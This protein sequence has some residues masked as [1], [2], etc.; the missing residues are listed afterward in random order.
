MYVAEDFNLTEAVDVDLTK[1]ITDTVKST[2]SDEEKADL[3]YKHIQELGN[4][5]KKTTLTEA[6]K[7]AED[8]ED[9]EEET[10][11]VTDKDPVED[12][13]LADMKG[14]VA[15]ALNGLLPEDA[16]DAEL[17]DTKHDMIDAVMAYFDDAD[18]IEYIKSLVYPE[19]A[20]D[21]DE[22]LVD[23]VEFEDA[24]AG[25]ETELTEIFGLGK[26]HPKL[27]TI[28]SAFEKYNQNFAVDPRDGAADV[29]SRKT[30]AITGSSLSVA[31][32]DSANK[33]NTK[34][35]V[36]KIEDNG[37]PKKFIRVETKPRDK[38][39][40]QAD[41]TNTND[42]P[43]YST[44]RIDDTYLSSYNQFTDKNTSKQDKHALSKQYKFKESV[45][46]DEVLQIVSNII[47]YDGS[48]IDPEEVPQLEKHLTDVHGKEIADQVMSILRSR[49]V[50]D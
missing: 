1:F 50:I 43:Y 11:E 22:D 45:D 18:S 28:K 48:H 24:E 42:Y 5:D 29:N 44:I 17:K 21:A 4:T 41:K 13:D 36:K 47:R 10:E 33:T 31:I 30:P 12:K 39:I 49:K 27:V 7:D 6:D 35:L 23:E 9:I 38:F 16:E 14:K 25:D 2:K 46:G 19:D 34:T 40:I 26:T 3:I 32:A 20:E 37:V 8:V 15:D